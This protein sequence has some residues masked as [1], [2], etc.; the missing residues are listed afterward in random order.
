MTENEDILEKRHRKKKKYKTMKVWLGVMIALCV[1]FLAACVFAGITLFKMNGTID[2]LN[3][4]VATVKDELQTVQLTADEFSANYNILVAEKEQLIAEKAKLEA[5]FTE[6]TQRLIQELQTLEENLSGSGASIDDLEDQID[7]KNKTISNL[8][9]KIKT[10]NSN[11]SKLESQIEDLKAQLTGDEPKDEPQTEEPKEEVKTP[12]TTE[13]VAYLTFDDGISDA[14]NDI[15]DILKKYNVK[16]TFFVNFAYKKISGYKEI[17]QRII[18]EGHTLGNHTSTHDFASVYGSVD[19]FEQEVMSIHNSIKEITGYEMSIFRFPGGSNT[20]YVKKL[21]TA[22]H[23]LIHDLGYEYY[24]WNVDSGDA[25]AHNVPSET[26]I[27]NVLSGAKYYNSAIIL[28]HDLGYKYK[29]TTVEALPEIIEG[30][31]DMG[32]ELKAM[33]DSVTPKQFTKDPNQ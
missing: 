7:E 14:T 25:T 4:Q 11:I 29:R 5:D 10:L 3:E 1:I 18:D 22:P 8:E 16:A 32:F 6:E 20:T 9:S 15:L 21:G 12:T 26:I 31:R 28:M 23:T 17:Y 13:K 33:D 30:L 2:D 27:N 19:G 24:D